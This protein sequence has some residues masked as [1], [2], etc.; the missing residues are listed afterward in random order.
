MCCTQNP[1]NPLRCLPFTLRFTDCGFALALTGFARAPGLRL[2]G[3]VWYWEMGSEWDPLELGEAV[4]LR[5]AA[6]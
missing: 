1:Q 4:M 6:G 3:G 5:L 2:N